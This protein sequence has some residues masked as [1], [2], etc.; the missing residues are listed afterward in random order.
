MCDMGRLIEEIALRNKH[1][2]FKDR[3]EAGEL[4]G[5][6]LMKYSDTPSVV[7]AIPSGGVPVGLA[8][9]RKADLPFDVIIV[10]KLQIPYE[11]EAGFGALG[12]DGEVVLNEPLLEHIGLTKEEIDNEIERTAAVIGKRT[13]LFR[14]GRPSPRLE[15][16][17]VI[18]VDDGLASG[19]TMRAAVQ[20]VKK[21]KPKKI[22]I[23]VP[24]ASDRTA[25]SLVKEVDELLCLNIRTGLSFAVA[26]AYSHWYD[27]EES[28]VLSL[29]ELH[30]P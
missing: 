3:L 7:L 17:N 13:E 23:A 4:L 29:L 8:I 11:R 2:I 25:R 10:R 27:L 15:D 26:D 20:H 1:R 22:V 12:P 24:T 28:E 18:I 9:A 6:K 19:Y 21:E 16:K 14:G 5:E 30:S